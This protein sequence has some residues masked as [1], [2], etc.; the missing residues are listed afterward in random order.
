MERRRPKRRRTTQAGNEENENGQGVRSLEDWHSPGV[1]AAVRQLAATLAG[2]TYGYTAQ[3]LATANITTNGEDWTESL[4]AT[5]EAATA[6][7]EL[8]AAARSA[9]RVPS[10]SMSDEAHS[11]KDR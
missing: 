5:I 9:F 6:R 3:P 7:L 11:D 10:S 8:L 4:L 2:G 1:R